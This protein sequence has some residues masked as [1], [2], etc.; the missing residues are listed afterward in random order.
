MNYKAGD[1][2]KFKLNSKT[3][4]TG[5]LAKSNVDGCFNIYTGND[6]IQNVSEKLIVKKIKNQNVQSVTIENLIELKTEDKLKALSPGRLKY[7]E[8]LN[9]ER[10][11]I[12]K[13]Y[14]LQWADNR[15]QICNSTE[16]LNVHHRVYGNVGN[17]KPNDLT[18]LCKD[19][20][21]LFHNPNKRL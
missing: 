16:N 5:R 13:E 19:C 12:K 21:S 14:A 3:T 17:E 8:Y 20:H 15:C 2:V 10:W 1:W 7:A 18:V 4:L 11:K 6:F 9:S